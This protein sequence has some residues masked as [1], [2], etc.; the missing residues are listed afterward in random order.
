MSN[1]GRPVDRPVP[2]ETLTSAKHVSRAIMAD[3]HPSLWEFL[4][5]Q[6][7]FGEIHK[8]GSLTLFVDGEKI[9]CVLNDRP[10]RTSCFL[11][12]DTLGELFARVDLGLMNGTL[13]WSG[14]GYRK[15]SRAKVY[16]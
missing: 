1:A 6:R 16:N 13:N 2:P 9:K 15:R 14:K 5:K 12:A 10:C 4:H 3:S 8:T 7:D 11:A